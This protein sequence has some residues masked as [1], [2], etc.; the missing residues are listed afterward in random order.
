MNIDTLGII[1]ANI[2]NASS[3]KLLLSYSDDEYLVHTN[4]EYVF[5]SL[6]K[7]QPFIYSKNSSNINPLITIYTCQYDVPEDLIK[8]IIDNGESVCVDTSLYV[9]LN[10]N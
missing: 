9:D 1:I 7:L 6:R 4:C 5:S 2:K 10:S 8:F 3:K